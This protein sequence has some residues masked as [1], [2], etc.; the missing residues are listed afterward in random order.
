M[1]LPISC[2]RS[3]VLLNPPPCRSQQTRS[4]LSKFS[5]CTNAIRP[6][7]WSIG[8]LGQQS[9]PTTVL[10][11][12]LLFQSGSFNSLIPGACIVTCT[13]QVTAS[14][15]TFF[16]I[17]TV[18]VDFKKNG[19]CWALPE[20]PILLQFLKQCQNSSKGLPQPPPSPFS[21][22]AWKKP[23]SYRL[24]SFRDEII[25]IIIRVFTKLITNGCKDDELI[26]MMMVMRIMLMKITKGL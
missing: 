3:L 6:E 19:L 25:M 13:Q 5:N 10:G 15:K 18:I 26:M 20:L 14:Y 8:D 9:I 1:C 17:N 12:N 24:P 11:E 23:F 4:K 2:R 22:N 21:D 7:S 16:I